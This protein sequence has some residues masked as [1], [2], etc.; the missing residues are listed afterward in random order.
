MDV[1]DC[2]GDG[3][4]GMVM[5]MKLWCWQQGYSNDDVGSYDADMAMAMWQLVL[6]FFKIYLTL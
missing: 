6:S 5:A 1:G 3:D 2:C 4:V